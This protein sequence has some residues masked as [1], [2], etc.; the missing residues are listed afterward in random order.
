[1]ARIKGVTGFSGS[2][3]SQISMPM[4]SFYCETFADLIDANEQKGHDGIAYLY[5][6][7]QAIVF[8]DVSK[9]GIYFLKDIANPN[10]AN[11]WEKVNAGNSSQDRIYY[12][13][14]PVTHTGYPLSNIAGILETFA[15][16]MSRISQDSGEYWFSNVNFMFVNLTAHSIIDNLKFENE[17]ELESWVNENVEKNNS[18]FIE[19]GYFI[20]YDII[21]K[22]I[23]PITKVKGFNSLFGGLVGGKG[24]TH[25]GHAEDCAW[26]KGYEM[27]ASLFNNIYHTSFDFE[28]FSNDFR[29]RRTIW[30]PRNY[31][32]YNKELVFTENS[33]TQISYNNSTVRYFYDTNNESWG[34]VNDNES[35]QNVWEIEDVYYLVADTGANPYFE[36]YNILNSRIPVSHYMLGGQGRG[37][38]VY[39][40]QNT[41][42]NEQKALQIKPIG[43]DSIVINYID[44]S[45][46]SL[47]IL[48][49]SEGEMQNFSYVKAINNVS[50]LV[51][52]E[53]LSDIYTGRIVLTK[54]DWMIGYRG[55]ANSVSHGKTKYP[56]IYFR[57]RD[58]QTKK[59]SVLSR[60]FISSRSS[61]LLP[62]TSEVKTDKM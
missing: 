6:Y 43:I 21:D 42:N 47:E 2:F 22:D 20:T 27:F 41:S 9:N 46:F 33:K 59:T 3:E 31:K 17:D 7:M 32:R 56:N 26:D 51:S 18:E 60:F 19:K 15:P 39:A 54:E 62:F 52:G 10:D 24:N 53:R 13:E 30:F 50:E 49:K 36:I 14:I 38:I 23:V 16:K 37:V 11:S 1:M 29:K 40:Y 57:L 35:S 12:D 8:N 28:D 25:K 61:G 55:Y 5:P 44:F 45:K 4:S 34:M 48:Q 58:K